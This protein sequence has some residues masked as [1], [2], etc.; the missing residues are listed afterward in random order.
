MDIF[1]W[2]RKCVEASVSSRRCIIHQQFRS[3]RWYLVCC[4]SLQHCRPRWSSVVIPS[5]SN[6]ESS[7]FSTRPSRL[8]PLTPPI[9]QRIRTC[10]WFH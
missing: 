1:S 10:G 2:R 6:R 8:H 7:L 3:D 5:R 9:S 4:T